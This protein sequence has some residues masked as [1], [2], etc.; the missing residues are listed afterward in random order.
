MFDF[1]ICKNSELSSFYQMVIHA[2]VKE[3]WKIV[4]V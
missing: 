1:V 3:L 4:M 2:H